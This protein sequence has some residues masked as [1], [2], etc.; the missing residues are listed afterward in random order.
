MCNARLRCLFAQRQTH[1]YSFPAQSGSSRKLATELGNLRVSSSLHIR[2]L[3]LRC[4]LRQ[5]PHR[6]CELVLT[7]ILHKLSAVTSRIY[8]VGLMAAPHKMQCHPSSYTSGESI[9]HLGTRDASVCSCN[10][11]PGAMIM[12]L[13]W[14]GESRVYSWLQP[15]AL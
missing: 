1:T 11:P 15:P 10:A 7:A 12:C 8:K 14:L 6:Y 13:R 2:L 4:D 5:E 3:L 9:G